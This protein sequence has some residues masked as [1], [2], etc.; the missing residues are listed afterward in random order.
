MRRPIRFVLSALASLALLTAPVA[1][2]AALAAPPLV[3]AVAADSEPLGPDPMPRKAEENPARELA[4]YEDREVQFTWGAA[5][6]LT[7]TGG[8]ALLVGIGLYFLLVHRPSQ[9]DRQAAARR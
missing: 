3:L 8:F 1:A 6:I 7:F 4:G 2:T 5:W 9:Q